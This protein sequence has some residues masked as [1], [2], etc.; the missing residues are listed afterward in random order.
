[1]NGTGDVGRRA[2][3]EVKERI[4]AKRDSS[5]GVQPRVDVDCSGHASRRPVL[6]IDP[7]VSLRIHRTLGSHNGFIVKRRVW[8]AELEVNSHCG[9]DGRVQVNVG[10][11]EVRSEPRRARWPEAVE[12]VQQYSGPRISDQAIS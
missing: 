1:M 3:P 9:Q 8:P 4:D 7:G 2:S 11:A 12:R 10:L 5:D 6:R